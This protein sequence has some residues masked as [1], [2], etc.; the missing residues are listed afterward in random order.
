MTNANNI[1][2]YQTFFNCKQPISQFTCVSKIIKLPPNNQM[3][4]KSTF[5]LSLLIAILIVNDVIAQRSF[6]DVG[7]ESTGERIKTEVC[8]KIFYY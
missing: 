1:S 7:S 8:K 6:K 4:S 3:K 2:T 5:I